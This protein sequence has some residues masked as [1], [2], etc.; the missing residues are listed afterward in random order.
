LKRLEESK[1]RVSTEELL[2]ELGDEF[3]E[4]ISEIDLEKAIE[5][6]KKMRDVEWKR[7][8]YDISKLIDAYKKNENIKGYTTIYNII[9]FPK[10]LEFDL[11]ALYLSK[12]DY[13]LA[14]DV[15]TKLLKLGKVIPVID[16]IISAITINKG[17]RFITRDKHFL[18]VRDIVKNFSVMVES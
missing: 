16:V 15:S 4:L 13:A 5:G 17:L 9:E 14:S 6:Y 7:F 18:F 12:Q 1:T 8:F 11:T 3:R 10:A 2:K